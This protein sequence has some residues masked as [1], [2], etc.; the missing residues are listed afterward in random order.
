MEKIKSIRPP[1]NC[2]VQT[3]QEHTHTQAKPK[4]RR[5]QTRAF[6]EHLISFRISPLS[7]SIDSPLGLRPQRLDS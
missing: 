7:Q 4:H 2:I 3:A 1:K 5:K 6:E